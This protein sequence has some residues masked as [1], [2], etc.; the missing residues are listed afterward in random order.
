MPN[1]NSV[2]GRRRDD[3]VFD[4]MIDDF[5]D[6]L[7]VSLKNGHNLL[8]V[9]VEDNGVLVVASSQDFAVIRGIDVDGQNTGNTGRMQRL[10]N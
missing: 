6:S 2:I 10:Y 1:A 4:W 5:G 9:F 8:R 7:G 3:G